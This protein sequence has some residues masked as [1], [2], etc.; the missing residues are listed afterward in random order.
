MADKIPL[1]NFQLAN[2]ADSSIQLIFRDLNAAACALV[3]PKF[4]AFDLCVLRAASIVNERFE[5]G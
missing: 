1:I 3:R 5:K 2:V 4:Y